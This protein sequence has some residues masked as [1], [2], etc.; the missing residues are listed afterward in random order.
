MIKVDFGAAEDQTSVLLG[1]VEEG[2]GT[3]LIR[4]GCSGKQKFEDGV[5]WRVVHDFMTTIGEAAQRQPLIV[6]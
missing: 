4:I 2:G 6:A 3:I 5:L 1:M